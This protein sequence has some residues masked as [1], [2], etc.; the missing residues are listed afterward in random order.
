MLTKTVTVYTKVLEKYMKIYDTYSTV[1]KDLLSGLDSLSN[2]YLTYEV[3][4]PVT[5]EIYLKVIKYDL[6]KSSPNYE[7]I[8]RHK[9]SY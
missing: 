4:D 2:V 1:F 6:Q 8:S 7:L 5:L 3:T 9:Y